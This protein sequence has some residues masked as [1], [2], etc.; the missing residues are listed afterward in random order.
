MLPKSKQQG[1]LNNLKVLSCVESL[2]IQKKEPSAAALNKWGVFFNSLWRSGCFR[3]GHES[4]L[5]LKWNAHAIRATHKNKSWRVITQMLSET[6]Q[7]YIFCP[8]ITKRI[9]ILPRPRPSTSCVFVHLTKSSSDS[10]EMKIFEQIFSL[11]LSPWLSPEIH[12]YFDFLVKPFGNTRDECG[13]ATAQTMY[14]IC[15]HQG[16]YHVRKTSIDKHKKDGTPH[17]RRPSERSLN[18]QTRIKRFQ[19]LIACSRI[20]CVESIVVVVG[21]CCLFFF[22]KQKAAT[23]LDWFCPIR[24]D[25]LCASFRENPNNSIFILSALSS[26]LSVHMCL[27]PLFNRRFH[28][29]ETFLRTTH[30]THWHTLTFYMP[31]IMRLGDK[32]VLWTFSEAFLRERMSN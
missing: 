3:S 14:G 26:R 10:S 5:M 22:A 19:H 16:I 24:V 9:K 23:I 20:D 7:N 21:C 31:W 1:Q 12:H 13:Q 2:F 17:A 27:S 8:T 28:R 30:C 25:C 18:K 15:M 11:F 6:K 29:L 4:W 32:H